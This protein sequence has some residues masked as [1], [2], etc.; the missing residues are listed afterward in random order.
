MLGEG[1]FIFTAGDVDNL[2]TTLEYVLDHP[3]ETANKK[4]LAR[5][6]ALERYSTA[7]TVEKLRSLIEELSKSMNL[8]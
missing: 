6:F 3:E 1:G 7:A 8:H 5:K 2:R 4:T